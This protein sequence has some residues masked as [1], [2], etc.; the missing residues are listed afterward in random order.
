MLNYF[1]HHRKLIRTFIKKIINLLIFIFNRHIFGAIY[2]HVF[3]GAEVSTL[4]TLAVVQNCF[5]EKCELLANL[6][7]N[8]SMNCERQKSSCPQNKKFQLCSPRV[9][10]FREKC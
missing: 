3:F 9:G 2:L 8:P 7:K 6:V 4:H 1:I 5:C 10:N